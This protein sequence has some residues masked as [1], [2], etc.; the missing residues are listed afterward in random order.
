MNIAVIGGGRWGKN[1]IRTAHKLDV[2]AAVIDSDPD[3][4]IYL[5]K[6]YPDVKFFKTINQ[7]GALDFNAYVVAIPAEHHFTVT[8]TLLEYKKHV[9]VEKP[10][11]LDVTEA[12]ELNSL[13]KKNE[14]QLMVG[15]LLLFH[16]AF[17][18]IKNFIDNGKLGKLQ[19]MY[20]NR[21]NLGTV[22]TEEN[23][24]FSFAP[25]DLSIFQYLTDD[26]PIT[27]SATGGAFLQPHVH[28]TTTTALSYPK[29]IKAHIFVSWLHP[30]KEHRLVVI[31]S[32]AMMVYEDSSQEKELLLYEKGIDFVNGKPIS[33]KGDI[34]KI[35]YDQKEPL[36][37]ELL[38]FIDC[39]NG[40]EENN[41]ISGVHGLNVLKTLHKAQ[42]SLDDVYELQ[43]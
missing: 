43:Y 11:T 8:K 32:K 25:H 19:Y 30:F 2:L 14:C 39:I 27:V 23:S 16:P 4:G 17:R 9:L 6:N 1:H 29:N 21:L 41:I 36:K 7:P 28:D 3:V 10:I 22:R 42:Q 34:K 12:E 37:E 26:E 33:R 5:K 31:G 13:A 38:H 40:T 15:H 35:N 20:S 24:L 18:K